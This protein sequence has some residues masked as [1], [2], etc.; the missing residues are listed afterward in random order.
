MSFTVER[1]LQCIQTEHTGEHLP[2]EKF[3][4]AIHDEEYAPGPFLRHV[5]GH[6]KP[7][8]VLGFDCNGMDY[9]DIYSIFAE[10]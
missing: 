1:A 10:D 2:M 7:F 5:A 4:R 9:A 3:L 8:R 6:G